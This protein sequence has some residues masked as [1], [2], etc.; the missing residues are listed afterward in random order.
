M[1]TRVHVNRHPSDRISLFTR[2]TLHCAACNKLPRSSLRASGSSEVETLFFKSLEVWAS[3]LKESTIKI[4][5]RK[6]S[7]QIASTMLEPRPDGLGKVALQLAHKRKIL[8][9][10]TYFNFA[11]NFTHFE[12]LNFRG[13][14]FKAILIHSIESFFNFSLF[15]FLVGIS[16]PLGVCTQCQS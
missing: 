14:W 6:R 12:Q 4:S 3:G 5:N 7:G 8:M 1:Q 16:K 2:T 11:F 13:R 9:I 15:I 10:L